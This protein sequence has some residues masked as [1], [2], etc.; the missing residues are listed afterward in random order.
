MLPPCTGG[1]ASLHRP[2][3]R[4]AD[5]ASRRL[6][7]FARL[8]RGSGRRFASAGPRCAACCRCARARVRPRLS[9]ALSWRSRSGRE[10]PRVSSSPVEPG[11]DPGSPGRAYERRTVPVPAREAAS[12]R[13]IQALFARSAAP[14]TSSAIAEAVAMCQF[15]WTRSSAAAPRPSRPPRPWARRRRPRRPRLRDPRSRSSRAARRR[16]T[17]CRARRRPRSHRTRATSGR[18]PV[19]RRRAKTRARATRARSAP[20]PDESHDRYSR[21][22][23]RPTNASTGPS[24]RR[25]PPM[26]P[27][28]RVSRL[29]LRVVERHHRTREIARRAGIE[30]VLDSREEPLFLLVRMKLDD[31]PERGDRA[32][33]LRSVERGFE[34]VGERFDR[35]RVAEATLDSPGFFR[36]GRGR[37]SDRRAAL[38]RR[39]A[40]KGPRPAGAGA[41]PECPR[42][43]ARPPHRAAGDSDDDVRGGSS[44]S[45]S[46]RDIARPRVVTSSHCSLRHIAHFVTCSHCS[47]RHFAH[48]A[49]RGGARLVPCARAPPTGA[50]VT[51]PVALSRPRRARNPRRPIPRSPR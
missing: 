16:R 48:F 12:S 23:G 22:A 29:D 19:R 1:N 3:E 14:A 38:R 42:F 45:W 20:A 44:L 35:L 50:W 46:G 24:A 10:R 9:Q 5:R 49:R 36:R 30:R 39:C 25:V 8:S 41:T 2:C 18:R 51:A 17:T 34:G 28:A 7:L 13:P 33:E 27:S 15:E 26:A 6:R 43:R 21:L 47:L 11:D 4:R 32:L 40:R 37:S 31:R